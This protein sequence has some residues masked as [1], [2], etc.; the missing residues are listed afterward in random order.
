[1]VLVPCRFCHHAVDTTATRTKQTGR[2]RMLVLCPMCGD[3][4]EIA[5][6]TSRWRALRRAV[7]GR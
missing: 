6:G 5:E 1:V 2:A 7:F 4:F 3:V